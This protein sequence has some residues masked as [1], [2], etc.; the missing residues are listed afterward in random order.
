MAE[1][2]HAAQ[3]EFAHRRTDQQ[4]GLPSG[5]YRLS[6]RSVVG[7]FGSRGRGTPRLR[8]WSQA[9]WTCPDRGTTARSWKEPCALV[10]RRSSPP[11][12]GKGAE[13]ERNRRPVKGRL[14]STVAS[15]EGGHATMFATSPG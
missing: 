9:P 8:R 12:S 3:A 10:S 11:R 14:H 2:M 4:V 15:D 13:G 7:P 6:E 5:A 1:G